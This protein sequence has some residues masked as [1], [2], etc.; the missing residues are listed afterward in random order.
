MQKAQVTFFPEKN[1]APKKGF[2]ER[3][4]F[5]RTTRLSVSTVTF[6]ID[7]FHNKELQ[8]IIDELLGCNNLLHTQQ[9]YCSKNGVAFVNNP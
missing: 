2:E 7:S 5:V 4:A 3:R 6:L 1:S 9:Y 8:A